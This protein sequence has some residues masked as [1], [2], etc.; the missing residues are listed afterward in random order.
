MG[1]PSTPETRIRSRND[2]ASVAALLT[3]RHSGH[4]MIWNLSEESYDSGLFENQVI[5][6]KFPGFPAP[7]LG[8]LFKICTSIENWLAADTANVAV[9]HC[10]VCAT[11]SNRFC[12]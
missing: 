8:L 4:F 1:F 2:A 5:E 6:V 9:V 11:T 12:V 10:M 7:P 3:E